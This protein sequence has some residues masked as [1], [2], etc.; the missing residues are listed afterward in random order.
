MQQ[1]LGHKDRRRQGRVEG[2]CQA[3][4]GSGRDEGPRLGQNSFH[5]VAHEPSDGPAHLH[6]RAFASQRQPAA[7]AEGAAD[8]FDRQYPSRRWMKM[9]PQ[10]RLDARNSA[11]GPLRG[12]SLGQITRESRPDRAKHYRHDPIDLS[13]AMVMR[14]NDH[15]S[16]QKIQFAQGKAERRAHDPGDR[17]HHRG[18]SHLNQPLPG[19]S[20]QAVFVLGHGVELRRGNGGRSLRRDGR[21][22][23]MAKILKQRHRLGQEQNAPARSCQRQMRSGPSSPTPSRAELTPTANDNGKDSAKTRRTQKGLRHR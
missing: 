18:K 13:D 8:E 17:A 11:P 10:H 9:I 19:P 4:P 22:R 3:R 1:F 20:R 23:S 12:Q 5:R 7:D 14:P 21:L 6:G 15:L 2:D 16:A